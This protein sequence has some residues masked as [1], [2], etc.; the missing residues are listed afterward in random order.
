MGEVVNTTA[1]KIFSSLGSMATMP[2]GSA[3]KTNPEYNHAP[4]T[5]MKNV[6]NIKTF[7]LSENLE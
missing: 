4:I 7:C 1:A 3:L 6:D 2:R 5:K